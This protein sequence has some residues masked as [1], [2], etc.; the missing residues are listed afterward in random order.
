MSAKMGNKQAEDCQRCQSPL[1]DLPMLYTLRGAAGTQIRSCLSKP[2]FHS[3][4]YYPTLTRFHT[5][6]TQLQ[7]E[8]YARKGSVQYKLRG[9]VT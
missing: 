9:K 6:A 5:V 2:I 3:R 4:I 8:D 1:H 7:E